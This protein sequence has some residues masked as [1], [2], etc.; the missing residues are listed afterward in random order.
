MIRAIFGV[1]V[2]LLLSGAALAQSCGSYPYTLT[3]GT[4]ADASQVMGN[5]NHVL[6]CVNNNQV[7]AS[8][9]RGWLGGLTMSNNVTSPNTV[10]D[11]AAGVANSDDAT[12]LMTLVAFTK[13][14]N[15]AWVVG[16]GNGCL[17]SGSTLAAST[18]YHLFV[19]ARTDTGVVDQLCSTSA[20]APTLP[21][22][23]TKKRRIGSFKTN[24]S[25]QILAFS[26][27]G[28]EFIWTTPVQDVNVGN[29]G[30]AVTIYPL[31]S[32][33]TGVR[34]NALMRGYMYH[35]TQASMNGSV[36][37]YD[38]GSTST[39]NPVGNFNIRPPGAGSS[40]ANWFNVRTSSSQQIRAV[41]NQSSTSLVL[42]VYGWIDTRGRFD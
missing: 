29:L 31:S 13:N 39:S 6:N 19:I 41:S 7:V 8:L 33:P 24:S 1:V 5:F 18:W 42:V 2:A 17:D 14:A 4:T 35:A 27:G 9:L 40:G 3:N 23:Y 12:T 38:D 15:A 30:T 34:V 36:F 28:D 16:T 10:I 25:S 21:I 22:S 20:T 11:T 26:Q 32:V 37:P